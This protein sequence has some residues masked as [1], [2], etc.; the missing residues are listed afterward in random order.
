MRLI[1]HNMLKCNIRNVENG[2]PLK[3]EASEVEVISTPIDR[4]EKSTRPRLYHSITKE[5]AIR[6]SK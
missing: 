1:T 5:D 2:Y 4:G 6:R 3:V